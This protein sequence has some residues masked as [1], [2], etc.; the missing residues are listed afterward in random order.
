MTKTTKKP[1]RTRK[2]RD[3]EALIKQEREHK[4][5]T[6]HLRGNFTNANDPRIDF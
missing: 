4:E 6:G 3:I 1:Y 5:R 2:Q